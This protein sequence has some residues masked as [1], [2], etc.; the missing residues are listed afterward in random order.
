M[1]EEVHIFHNDFFRRVDP[2]PHEIQDTTYA[3]LDQVVG[4]ALRAFRRRDDDPDF[5]A[6]GVH[7]E[8]RAARTRN[9]QP[10]NLLADLERVAVEGPH[11]VEAAGLEFGMMQQRAAEVAHPDQ[12]GAPFTVNARGN[13][14]G[15]DEA[16]YVI[17]CATHAGF[18]KIG[19]A[20]AY[21][22]CIHVARF[23]ERTRGDDLHTVALYTFEHLNVYGRATNGGSGN[24]FAFR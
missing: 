21:L 24:M 5:N 7:G 10:I 2:G 4:R 15:G 18:V 20:L 23:S 1:V 8:L 19:E 11:N 14:D 16:D 22:R 12:R 6:L 17:S 13:F 9:F 3:R